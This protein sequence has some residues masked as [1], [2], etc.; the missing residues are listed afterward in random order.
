M[1]S[2]HSVVRVEQPTLSAPAPIRGRVIGA[3]SRGQRF[4]R[5]KRSFDLVATAVLLAL[6]AP[7]LLVIAL[8][9][10]VESG[11]PVIF[12]QERVGARRRPGAEPDSS[13]W[14][15][16]VFRFYKFRSMVVGA[17]P[18]IHKAH[19]ESFV[20]GDAPPE[21]GS[22]KLQ[23]D[24]RITGV[25]RVMRAVSLDEL[26]QLVNVLKGDMSLVGPRPLPAYEVELYECEHLERFTAPS[27]ITGFWQV[28]GR[29][30]L[31][32][33]RM[34]ELDLDYVRRQSLMRDLGILLRTLP[35]VLAQRGAG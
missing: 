9:I 27:G 25:G 35:A 2:T 10:V 32:F 14:E 8:A 19:I 26:A 24:A 17:D 13:S 4:Y 22:F 15:L 12:S 28:A 3:S 29:A 5:A 11:R 1:S 23:D 33:V 21:A 7:V 31:P 30:E 34:I 18:A 6:L 16:S 20:N